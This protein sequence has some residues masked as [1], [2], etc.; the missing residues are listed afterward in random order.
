MSDIEEMV[1]RNPSPQIAKYGLSFHIKVLLL[2]VL[3]FEG[4]AENA[5]SWEG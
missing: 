1:P 5:A 2:W 4:A 3:K